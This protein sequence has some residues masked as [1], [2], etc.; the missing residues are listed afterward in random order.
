MKYIHL[1]VIWLA[2][3]CLVAPTLRGEEVGMDDLNA[4]VKLKVRADG[5][6]SIRQIQQV[7]DRLQAALDKGLDAENTDFAERLLVSTLVERATLLCSGIFDTPRPDPRWMQIR[8]LALNDLRRAIALDDSQAQ[9]HM[10]VGRLQALPGGDREEAARSLTRF[11]AAE[12]V[13]DWQRA[14]ALMVRAELQTDAEARLA[15]F[16]KAI[17]L[18]PDRPEHYRTR[19][20]YF[21]GRQDFKEAVA[22][23]DRAIE[24][25]PGD[26]ATHV[27]RG[28]VLMEMDQHE[29]ALKSFDRAIEINP[30]LTAALQHRGEVYERLGNL[31]RALEQLDLAIR[32][33]PESVLTLL[34]RAR[35]RLLAEDWDGAIAD[36]DRIL[37][38]RPDTI[39]A[40]LFRAEALAGAD[41]L[42]EAI[43]QMERLTNQIPEE[44]NIRLQLANY[45]VRRKQP[46]RAIETYSEVI[47][48]EPE[49]QLAWRG[50]A[51]AYLNIGQHREAIHDFQQALDN[52]GDEESVADPSLLNNFAWVLATSPLSD[53]RD[54]GKAIELATK[55]CELTQFNAP[56][57][58]STLAAAYAE[59]G[60]FATAVEWSQKAVDIG[61]E[62]YNEQ[63]KNELKTYQQGKPFREQQEQEEFEAGAQELLPSESA[64]VPA[65]TSDF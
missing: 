39:A 16:A 59:S 49:N 29:E 35:L 1:A 21:S 26:A 60:D 62:Q 57:I 20:I 33:Q 56:H 14:A 34:Q 5:P 23:L 63:L 11:L 50:R 52:Y 31:P 30:K 64:A 45:Y 6:Q 12:E 8:L 37:K 58:L 53:V 55:A 43:L 54:G 4:A 51:D 24:L 13:E 38:A 28:A 25:A 36:A 65:R 3:A 2:V 46:R 40:H 41:R 48:R 47:R 22:D 61:D 17:E 27:L 32:Q 15:D 19:A 18:A 10:L 42:G 9:A 44:P 7:L